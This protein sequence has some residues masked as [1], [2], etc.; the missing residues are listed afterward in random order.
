MNSKKAFLRITFLF[1]SVFLILGSLNGCG[2]DPPSSSGKITILGSTIS[3]KVEFII[4]NMSIDEKVGQM[5]MI[6]RSV[7]GGS[8]ISSYYIG[9]VLSGG[10]SH[11]ADNTPSG[12]ANMYDTMQAKA[13]ND[14]RFGIPIL[15]GI[16]AVHGNN[17]L[18]GA[19]IFPHNIGLGCMSNTALVQQASEITAE[20]VY[21]TGMNW[22]FSPCVA[23][24]R[25][26]RWGRTYEGYGETSDLVKFMGYASIQG[27]Q[28]P[29]LGTANR[30]LACAKHYVGD[31]GTTDGID[32]GNT[33]DGGTIASIHTPPFTEAIAAGVGSIMISFSSV[34]GADM[35][36]HQNLISQVL[37]TNMGFDGIVL[38]DWGGVDKLSGADFKDKIKRAINAGIDMVMLPFVYSSFTTYLKELVSQGDVSMTRIDD[39]VRRILTIK[40]RMGLFDS[41]YAD[42]TLIDS[43]GSAAHRDVARECVRESLVLLTNF[44][45]ILPI[46]TSNSIH[47]AGKNADDLGN[48]CGGWT[49]EWQGLSGNTLTIG[50]TIKQGFDS[51]TTGTVTYSLDGSGATGSEDFGIVVI[52]ETPYAEDRGDTNDLSL[53][54]ADVL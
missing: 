34:D 52:G 31:G 37:K 15:Y 9:A 33:I 32:Q 8:A 27:Y 29:S 2:D 13:V 28:G 46:Y 51:L 43:I 45:N 41:P 36:Q 17:N 47:I 38:S 35:H 50:T 10:G 26:E 44:N 20:E 39:A 23:V 53:S 42:R 30:I 24:P 7:A 6:E 22:T 18:K 12:W 16:D 1:L 19:V 3:E 49:I 5:S 40:Y 21:P 48:Q 4:S 11:P 14:T 54:A 25:N